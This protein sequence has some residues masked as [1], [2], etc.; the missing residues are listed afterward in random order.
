MSTI[1]HVALS[2]SAASLAYANRARAAAPRP[3]SINIASSDSVSL[4]PEA[5]AVDDGLH[6]EKVRRVR[7]SLAD[8]TYLNPEKFDKAIDRLLADI[9]RIG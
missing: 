8:G 4:S 3:V 2:P 5:Q 7:Q 1:D 9:D 6:G